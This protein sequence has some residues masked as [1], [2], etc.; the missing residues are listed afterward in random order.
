[1]SARSDKAYKR[2][3]PSKQIR[4]DCYQAFDRKALIDICERDSLSFTDYATLY[5]LPGH[6]RFYYYQD[7][8]SDILAVAHL[9]TVQS[10]R[11]CQVINTA[12][13]M[14]AVSGALDDRLGAYIILELL[15]AIGIKCDVLLTTDEEHGQST[16]QDFTSDKHYN[17]IIQFDRGGTDVVMYEYETP[18]MCKLV[19]EADAKV[20][21][22]TYSDICNLEHLG[23]KA[24][25]WGTGYADYHS[26]RSHAWI[27][28]TLRMVARF[29]N[30][31]K[32]NATTYLEHDEQP[33]WTS[34]SGSSNWWETYRYTKALVSTDSSDEY[35]EA[36]CGHLIN[37]DNPYSYKETA[38]GYYVCIKC[39]D[40][41]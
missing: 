32:H 16:A 10:N 9:D 5:P 14:L 15:P 35:L 33:R 19:T 26:A 2:S 27:D 11:S 20:G 13:G 40:L 6:E 37:L 34:Y 12:S 36:D 31:H 22:G 8:G 30:F 39:T 41:I 21:I 38:G 24:F 4:R 23:C 25:N 7:N 18:A 28:D 1:M 17:W 29:A 3:Q